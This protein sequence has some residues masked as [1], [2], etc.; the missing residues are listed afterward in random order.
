MPRNH[1]HR[2]VRDYCQA[3]RCRRMTQKEA[4]RTHTSWNGI[5]VGPLNPWGNLSA[6]GPGTKPMYIWVLVAGIA[7]E[8]FLG[9]DIV[10]TWCIR[11]LGEPHAATRRENNAIGPQDGAPVF[12]SYGGLRPCG[13][14]RMRGS[15]DDSAG[16]IEPTSET[17]TPEGLYRAG[18][19][20]GTGERYPLKF[21]TIPA[22]A[23]HWRK[24]PSRHTAN[25]SLRLPYKL[26]RHAW[27]KTPSHSCRMGLR[28]PGQTWTTK[29][30][31]NWRNWLRNTKTLLRRM[32]VTTGGPTLYSTASTL[33]KPVLFDNPQGGFP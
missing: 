28:L 24:D 16:L 17:H 10:H 14:G 22:S 29:K 8:H 1:Q 23:R 18:P 12:P 2:S 6:T 7:E 3:R 20:S 33:K 15:G 21:W 27:L 4:E 30:S 25:H 5:R 31:E 11:G 13:T 19:S 26:L 9:L 32:A